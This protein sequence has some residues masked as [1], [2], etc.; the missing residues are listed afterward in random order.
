MA[1]PVRSV[2]TLSSNGATAAVE[3]AIR[4]AERR[5]LRIC[6]VVLD[7]AGR[8]IAGRCM[9]GA[10]NSASEVALAKARHSANFR[11][12]TKHQE[13]LLMSKNALP[14]LAVPGMMPLEGDCRSRL[15]ARWWERSAFRVAPSI[16][17]ASSPLRGPLQSGPRHDAFKAHFGGKRDTCT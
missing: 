11:R 15:T 10:T 12:S 17:T 16:R 6:A 3:G 2:L 1:N 13:E 4:E 7:E 9:D 14:I 8:F 5:G